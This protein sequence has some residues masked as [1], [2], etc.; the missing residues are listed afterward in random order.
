MMSTVFAPAA[1]TNVWTRGAGL[2]LF[3]A[4][5]GCGSSGTTDR[6][7]GKDTLVVARVKDA[8]TLDPAAA[9]DGLSLNVTQEVLWGLVRFKP[10]SFEVAPALARQWRSS[11]D[12]KTWTF[13][14][15][16]GLKFSDGTAVN[17]PAVKFNFDRW[18]LRDNPEHRNDPYVYYATMFG[19]FPGAIVDVQAPNAMTVV[20]KLS[21][22]QASFLHN[23]AMPSFAI[24]SPTALRHDH[25]GFARAPVGYGPYT[26][27]E[28]VKDD[29]IT[30]KANSLYKEL[31]TPTYKTVIVRDI[32]DQATSVLSMESGEIDIL[33]D[34]RPDDAKTL[35][36]KSGLTVFEQPSNNNAYVAMNTDKSPFEKLAVRQAV[37]Y[38]MN[39]EQIVHA[40]YDRGAIVADNW[41]PPGMLGENHAVKHYP[42]DVTKA[43]SL[44][45]RA[46]V[47]G[48]ST[49]L[50]YPTAPRPYMPEPQR[51]AEAI[52][53][54]LKNAGVNVTLIPLEWATFLAK[55]RAGE[56][57]MCLIGWSGDNGDPDNFMYSLLDKDGANAKPNG[58]NYSFWRDDRF[59]SLML[60]GQATTDESKRAAI[61]R[62]ANAL[63][64]DQAPAI[65]IV[66]TTV[67][68]VVKSSI[69][70]F[71]PKPDTAINFELLRPKS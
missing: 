71:V 29:H 65:P 4:L 15:K 38:A 20:F 21:R 11:A 45:A 52:Q 18:R 3:L 62:R 70:G 2:V 48:F 37:A 27:A 57:P 31:P 67:P 13:T 9:A 54:N 35:A 41:T 19:G 58:Q 43:K 49:Q 44:L 6:T 47:A 34:P 7:P 36:Q 23:V 60:A 55:V 32:P 16:E 50:Y 64:H 61:Y 5:A 33:A 12:G 8:I 51:I 1:C 30:L 39:V 24:G 22:A 66:H 28:W 63:I 46:G 25:D 56:H 42:F 10:G 59:H 53:A 69:A 68:I 40:F 14:L 26:V 17:A